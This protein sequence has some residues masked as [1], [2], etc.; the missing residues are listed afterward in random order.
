MF[1]YTIE[2]VELS[3]SFL[4]YYSVFIRLLHPITTLV[5]LCVSGSVPYW[6]P[7]SLL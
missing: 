4:Q 3:P 7:L 1:S 2:K 5:Q 6:M